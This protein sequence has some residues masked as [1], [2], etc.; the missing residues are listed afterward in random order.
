MSISSQIIEEL[1]REFL[2]LRQK[3]HDLREYL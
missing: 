3:I 1:E 2:P